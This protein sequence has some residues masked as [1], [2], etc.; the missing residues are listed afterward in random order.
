MPE[1]LFRHSYYPLAKTIC[2]MHA[3]FNKFSI[4]DFKGVYCFQKT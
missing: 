1:C 2:F 3:I 4:L